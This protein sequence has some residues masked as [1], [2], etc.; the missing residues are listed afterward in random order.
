MKLKIKTETVKKSKLEKAARKYTVSFSVKK[1]TK[2]LTP[3]PVKVNIVNN[4]KRKAIARYE[5]SLAVYPILRKMRIGA[6]VFVTRKAYQHF[7][8][9]AKRAGFKIESRQGRNDTNKVR[10]WKLA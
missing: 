3:T 9:Q 10:I 7:Y 1:Y 6:S 4:V 2:E 5:N 8:Y